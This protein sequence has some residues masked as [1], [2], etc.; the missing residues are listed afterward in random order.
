MTLPRCAEC[1]SPP[2]R[3][4]VVMRCGEVVMRRGHAASRSGDHRVA[5]V[6]RGG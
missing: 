2:L 6:S 3:G 4:D 1:S 5:E